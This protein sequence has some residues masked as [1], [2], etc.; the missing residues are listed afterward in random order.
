MCRMCSTGLAADEHELVEL[1]T[2]TSIAG[3]DKSA[4]V[5]PTWPYC[6]LNITGRLV[7][8]GYSGMLKQTITRLTDLGQ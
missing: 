5:W 1:P 3:L 7:M 2:D 8:H 6:I 4:A